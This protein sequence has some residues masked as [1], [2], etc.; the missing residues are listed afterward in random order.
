MPVH[1]GRIDYLNIWHIFHLL[2]RYC[3]EGA[4]YHYVPGHP[5]QLNHALARGDLD[6]SPSSSFEYLVRAEHYQLL[7]AASISAHTEVQSV[8]LVSPAPLDD[9]CAWLAHNPGPVLLT[10]ASA[11]STALLKILWTQKWGFAEPD[12]QDIEPGKGLASGRP[13]LEIGNFALRHFVCPPQGYHCID[14]ATEWST[15]TGLPFV[16]AVWIMRRA[17]PAQARALL[18]L[19]QRHIAT[20]TT[21]LDQHFPALSGLSVR[22]D[23]LTQAE[24]VRYWQAM[25]YTLDAREQAGLALFGECCT[26]QGLLAGM[27]ALRWFEE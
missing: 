3:P 15:W 27:P 16:F 18:A 6:I 5:S 7:P 17:L 1:I 14:L 26:R 8:L 4:E 24:L 2:T 21:T 19:L 22:P 20:L 23:W 12:W 9:L 10:S 13:F 11:T 25:S